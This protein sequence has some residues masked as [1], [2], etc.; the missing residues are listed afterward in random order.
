MSRPLTKNIFIEYNPSASFT[1]AKEHNGEI[2]SLHRLYVECSDPTE[3]RFVREVLKDEQL[4]ATLTKDKFFAPYL[5]EMRLELQTKL[6]ADAIQAII[7]ISQNKNSGARLN[8]SKYLL[9]Q[10]FDV[11]RRGRPS[12]KEVEEAV[13]EEIKLERQMLEDLKRLS[14]SMRIDLQ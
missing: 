14:P 3:Y 5:D 6:K 2:K 8:A 11:K 9:E 4:W 13:R 1:L 10:G 7:E 12:K